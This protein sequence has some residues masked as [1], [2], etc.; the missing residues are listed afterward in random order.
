M[1][2]VPSFAF[3]QAV[4]PSFP[5][6]GEFTFDVSFGGNVFAQLPV[7]QF[8]MEAELKNSKKLAKNGSGIRH[9][10]NEAIKFQHPKKPRLTTSTTLPSMN[11][12]E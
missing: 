1:E 2:N 11:T 9:I 8:G 7:E 3:R 10:V 5:G 4:K 6:Y 12:T